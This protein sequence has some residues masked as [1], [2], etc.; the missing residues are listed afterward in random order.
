[1][2]PSAAPGERGGAA[3]RYSPAAGFHN[4][5]TNGF[6]ADQRGRQIRPKEQEPCQ[7]KLSMA[8]SGTPAKEWRSP[9]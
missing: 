1:L 4:R 6:P 8:G 2:I 7:N 5:A 9:G 3:L